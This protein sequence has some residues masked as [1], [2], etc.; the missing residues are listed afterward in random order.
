MPDRHRVNRIY[1]AD[2]ILQVRCTCGASEWITT[3]Q[4][5][6]DWEFRHARLVE[7]ALANLGRGDHSLKRHRDW[8]ERQAQDERNTAQERL[9]WQALADEATTHLGD[10]QIVDDEP[11][12]G[13]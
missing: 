5:A 11:L 4:Q 6:E 2:G 13:L 1:G 8:C 10:R 12:E 7:R 9:L 3:H